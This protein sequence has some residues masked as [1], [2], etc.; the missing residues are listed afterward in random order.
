MKRR[1]VVVRFVFFALCVGAVLFATPA[2]EGRA[3][4]DEDLFDEF[5]SVEEQESIDTVPSDKFVD[6]HFVDIKCCVS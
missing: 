6:M 5:D 2:V 3:V 1:S 4:A